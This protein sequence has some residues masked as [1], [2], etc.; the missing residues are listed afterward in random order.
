MGK[1]LSCEA[2][3]G[4]ACLTGPWSW[5]ARKMVELP[6]KAVLPGVVMMREQEKDRR[7]GYRALWACTGG[8]EAMGH[9]C[10]PFAL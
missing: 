4:A 5:K 1:A 10:I 2:G 6:G 8:R 3:K 9:G 7:L